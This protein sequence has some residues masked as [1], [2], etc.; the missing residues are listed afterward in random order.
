MRKKA[1]LIFVLRLVKMAAAIFNLVLSARFFGVSLERDIWILAFNSIIILDAAIWGPI[2]E[3]FRAKFLFIRE[4][5][6]EEEALKKASSLLLFTNAV[7]IVLVLILFIFPKYFAS[8]IAPSYRGEQQEFLIFMIRVV[9]PSFLIT[10][11]TKLLSSVLNAYSSFTI[12][13]LSGL[14]SQVFT[15]VIILTLA[16]SFGIISLAIAYYLGLGLLLILLLIQLKKRKINIWQNPSLFRFN[17]ITPFIY[18]ALP[19]FAPYFFAQLNLVV[20]KALA[21]S[22]RTGAVSAV[23]YGRKFSDIFLEV[24]LTVLFSMLVP[25][26]SSKF[27][28]NDEKEFLSEF[29]RMYQFGFLVLILVTGMM[30]ACPVA[31]VNLLYEQGS[32]PAADLSVISKLAM[33]YSWAAVGIFLYHIFGIALLSSQKGKI[34][35]FYGTFAQMLLVV[36][37]L[38]FYHIGNVYIFPF[39]LLASHFIAAVIMY[40]KFPV[41]SHRLQYVT[42]KYM[43]ALLVVVTTMFLANHF[44][45]NIE[46]PFLLIITNFALLLTLS[47][48]SAF[49]FKLEERL[50][51]LQYYRRL[52]S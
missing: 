11:V 33:Y 44:V 22:T 36:L 1:S 35:A 20:E 39:S 46:V 32:I 52:V 26:L 13:E 28:Q 34:Y 38:T 29:K 2:N 9:V 45:I 48:V 47:T 19:F 31:F 24:L 42:I 10:Q 40:F 27:A 21:S 30:T 17:Q 12:P 49:I 14:F 6:G 7:T 50:L 41:K 18:Y 25:M 5:Q 4:V 8:V 51:I 43:T 37:N 15:F 16:P 3:T 23:D